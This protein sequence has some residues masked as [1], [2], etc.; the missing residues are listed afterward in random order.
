L[1]PIHATRGLPNL[2]EVPLGIASIEDKTAQRAVVELR[3]VI[4]AQQFP[5]FSCGLGHNRS[6]HD[7]LD[8]LCLG[9]RNTAVSWTRRRDVYVLG[10]VFICGKSKRGSFC[11]GGRLTAIECVEKLQMIKADLRPKMHD[12]VRGSGGAPCALS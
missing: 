12:T 8:A 7:A 4:Y 9:I 5:G 3:N 6:R 1:S 10:F 2:T 11:F